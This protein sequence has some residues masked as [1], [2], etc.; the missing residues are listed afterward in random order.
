MAARELPGLAGIGQ[1]PWDG[2]GPC[3]GFMS[4]FSRF[5]RDKSGIGAIEFAIIAPV[6]L[7]LYIGALQVTIGLNFAKKASRAAG[8]V[9][10]AVTRA[11]ATVN[12]AFLAQMPNAARSIFAPFGTDGMTVKITG[13]SVDAASNA[14]VAW[15]WSESGPPYAASSA[16]SMPND[17]KK[18]GTF[19]VHAELTVPYKVFEFGADFLPSTMKEITIKRDYY[20]WQREGKAIS[21]SDC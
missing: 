7:I 6:L 2:T 10:D 4:V 20:Y 13:I 14:K 8:T 5:L 21:C 15:S 9:A 12:K 1:S 3:R 18:P 11:E 17:M 19:L 16:A